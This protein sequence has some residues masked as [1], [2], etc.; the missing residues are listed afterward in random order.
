MHSTVD[1]EVLLDYVILS[2][3]CMYDMILTVYW[4]SVVALQHRS[5]LYHVLGVHHTPNSICDLDTPQYI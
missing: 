3:V 2:V 5:R 1:L 4:T